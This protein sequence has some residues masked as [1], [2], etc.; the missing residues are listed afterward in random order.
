MSFVLKSDKEKKAYEKTIGESFQNNSVQQ[1]M[2]EDYNNSI[3]KYL[4]E[5]IGADF[6]SPETD[7]EKAELLPIEQEEADLEKTQPISLK[8]EELLDR[9]A[10]FCCFSSKKV[11]V[12]TKKV[13]RIGRSSKQSNIV[14]KNFRISSLHAIISYDENQF[15]IRDSDSK[16][17]TLLDQKEQLRGLQKVELNNCNLISLAGENCLFVTDQ[18]AEWILKNKRCALLECKETG[19]MQVL[20]ADKRFLLGRSNKWKAGA[21]TDHRISRELAY[22]Y[23]ED[24][25]C[26]LETVQHE[27]TSKTFLNKRLLLPSERMELKSGDELKMEHIY[28]IKFYWREFTQIK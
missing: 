13:N 17:G 20:D 28:H 25:K 16:N 15:Y 24:G 19:E 14:I 8:K 6:V 5:S 18:F 11:F 23:F 3:N 1:S 26:I 4:F 27:T 12:L 2:D 22:L 7:S 9:T 21:F 10:I